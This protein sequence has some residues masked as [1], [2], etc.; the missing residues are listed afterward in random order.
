MLVEAS[1]T[2]ATPLEQ[3]ETLEQLR[4]LENGIKIKVMRFETRGWQST[5]RKM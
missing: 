3:S 4:A 5:F 1:G 2:K